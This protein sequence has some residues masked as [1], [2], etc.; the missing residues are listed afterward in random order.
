ML[1]V[2]SKT[3][4]D[5]YRSE[6]ACDIVAAKNNSLVPSDPSAVRGHQVMIPGKQSL[7]PRDDD[8]IC[9][10][11]EIRLEDTYNID[12]SFFSLNFD[13]ESL[14]DRYS[15]EKIVFNSSDQIINKYRKTQAY[16]SSSESILEVFA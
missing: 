14:K 1:P 2:R 3:E 13:T 9:L 7:T 15:I 12:R 10:D 4:G 11:T 6:M 5:G 16:R 8:A